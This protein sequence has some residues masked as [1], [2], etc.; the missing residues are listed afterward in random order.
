M[1]AKQKRPRR[2]THRDLRW[3]LNSLLT[4]QIEQGLKQSL[5][6]FWRDLN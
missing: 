5:K 4:R 1:A 6:R 3:R 2:L